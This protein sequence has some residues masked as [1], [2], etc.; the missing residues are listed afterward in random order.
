MSILAASTAVSSNILTNIPFFRLPKNQVSTAE[1][2][3][4]KTYFGSRYNPTKIAKPSCE[5]NSHS[6]IGIY[7]LPSQVSED[8]W[9]ARALLRSVVMNSLFKCFLA[10]WS[11]LFC[12]VAKRDESDN[13]EFVRAKD[14]KR[15]IKTAK[16]YNV[17]I[18]FDKSKAL[19]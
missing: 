5:R 18:L 16:S 13:F 10:A 2:S 12:W 17:S 11:R 4:Y 15:P 7:G 8:A 14:I 6:G 3:M 19:E 9:L 1:M